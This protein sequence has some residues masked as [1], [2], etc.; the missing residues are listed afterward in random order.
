M[1]ED[2]SMWRDFEN[3]KVYVKSG[4]EIIEVPHAIA[5]A[6][7]RYEADSFRLYHAMI[8][9][10]ERLTAENIKLRKVIQHLYACAMNS[11]CIGC[12][13]DGKVCDFDH[14]LRLLGIEV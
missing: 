2:F 13:Y 10:S 7:R 9:R 3:N 14:D 12:P 1:I 5:E 4:T 8:E 6:Y 11:G